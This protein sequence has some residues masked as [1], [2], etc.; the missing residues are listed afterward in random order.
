MPGTTELHPNLA[1][2]SEGQRILGRFVLSRMLRE[3]AWGATWLGR[4]E[5]TG[6]EVVIKALAEVIARDVV[7]IADLKHEIQRLRDLQ[8]EVF[9]A[10]WELHQDDSLAALVR[11]FVPGASLEALRDVRIHGCFEA[12]ELLSL[13]E[14]LGPAFIQAHERLRMVHRAL[15]PGQFILDPDGALRILDFGI[16]HALLEAGARHAESKRDGAST[17]YAS[18]HVVAGG[19]PIPT[20]DIYSL[21]AVLHALLTGVPPSSR[22]GLPEE[23][24]DGDGISME[25]RRAALNRWGASIPPWWE[26]MIASCLAEDPAERP[27][28]VR[29]MIDA[30]RTGIEVV[31]PRADLLE[32]A[33]PVIEKVAPPIPSQPQDIAGMIPA[34]NRKETSPMEPPVVVIKKNEATA[35]VESVSSSTLPEIETAQGAAV[36][37][38]HHRGTLVALVALGIAILAVR[39]VSDRLLPPVVPEAP[40]AGET[41]GLRTGADPDGDPRASEPP[42]VVV[43]EDIKPDPAAEVP[44]QPLPDPGPVAS[45]PGESDPKAAETPSIA[46]PGGNEAPAVAPDEPAKEPPSEPE[47]MEVQPDPADVA[48]IPPAD[49]SSGLDPNGP[50]AIPPPILGG[51]KPSLVI[52]TPD[53]KMLAS[54]PNQ[55]A[56]DLLSPPSSP[57]PPSNEQP[58]PVPESASGEKAP[59]R[60]EPMPSTRPPVVGRP[61]TNSLGM[62]F[63]P[64]GKLPILIAIWETRVR[65]YEAFVKGTGTPWKGPGENADPNEP[66]VNVSFLDATLFC[67]WLTATEEASGNLQPGQRYRLP[68]D[69]EWSAA[70][71][72]PEEKGASPRERDDSKDKTVLWE[73]AW[74]PKP[75]AGNFQGLNPGNTP[76][77]GD[78]FEGLAPVGRFHPN[79]LGIFDLGGNAAEMVTDLVSPDGGK[80]VIRGGSFQDKSRQV[81][82]ARARGVGE[83]T[84]GV[85][86]NVGFRMALD[87]VVK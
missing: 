65:D 23:S 72:L 14:P 43:T 47:K 84:R 6:Q 74:P 38:A 30:L 35:A 77:V 81:L 67:E 60:A 1:A 80:H 75:D 82:R 27:N 61:W 49:A 70:A 71:G 73:G 4:D 26:L 64:V 79:A 17:P 76:G 40:T 29:V 10:K 55:P 54:V 42:A 33:S 21:G 8:H 34:E 56:P 85:M 15:H 36:Q 50:A 18:P 3:S 2:L 39:L 46:I 32:P 52:A 24:P 44:A 20:D 86:P 11:D 22:D 5:T 69:A 57:T 68:T 78:D 48:T 19:L 62:P 53:P 45:T 63:V 12:E 9:P 87:P 16:S 31:G 59:R 83:D 66:V 7:A 41:T 37:K 13:V 51:G 28:S 58:A 25:E